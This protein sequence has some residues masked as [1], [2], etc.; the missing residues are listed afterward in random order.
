MGTSTEEL[1][2]D[3]AQTRQSL[4]PGIACARPSPTG[5]APRRPCSGASEAVRPSSLHS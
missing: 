1:S 4:T 3:I 5:K 2:S